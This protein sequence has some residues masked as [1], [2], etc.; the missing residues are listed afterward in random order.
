MS[1]QYLQFEFNTPVAIIGD[2]HESFRELQI[3]IDKLP[4]DAVLVFVGDYFDKSKPHFPGQP[5]IE[6]VLPTL[7]LLERLNDS[8]NVHLIAGNHERAIVRYL[9]KK[10]HLEPE[11]V[12]TAFNSIEVFQSNP[13]M[14]KRLE[15]LYEQMSTGLVLSVEGF[16]SVLVSHAPV[17]PVYFE[18]DDAIAQRE[19]SNLRM[20]REPEAVIEAVS[21]IIKAKLNEKHTLHVFGHLA[22]GGLPKEVNRR[23]FLDTGAVAGNKLSALL[24]HKGQRRFVT[25]DSF[26]EPSDYAVDLSNW[27][28]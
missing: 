8:R 24:L 16:G 25:V 28:P 22:I 7:E 18:S 11:L 23:I 5:A 1:L 12:K 17:D 3:L 13:E 14:F 4:A 26:A 10:I 27:N 9:G 21:P 19:R 2:V 15:A 20:Q 6:R